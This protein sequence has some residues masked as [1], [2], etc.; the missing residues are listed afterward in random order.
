[1][2]KYRY[3]LQR[4]FFFF[5]DYDDANLLTPRDVINTDDSDI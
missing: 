2:T 4:Q 1:M 3:L 5:E